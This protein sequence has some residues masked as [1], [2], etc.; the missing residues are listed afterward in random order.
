MNPVPTDTIESRM[1]GWRSGEIRKCS[2]VAEVCD[3]EMSEH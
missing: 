1:K 3:S 2:C